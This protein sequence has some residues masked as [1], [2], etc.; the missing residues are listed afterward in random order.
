MLANTYK[1][2]RGMS[3]GPELSPA[4]SK[5][6]ESAKEDERILRNIFFCHSQAFS[7][8][9]SAFMLYFETVLKSPDTQRLLLTFS[10][11]Y[12]IFRFCHFTEVKN[13]SAK[14]V[15]CFKF[16]LYA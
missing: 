5:L 7:E 12:E 2:Q 9:I 6:L 15:W 16:Q 4:I 11:V 8:L 1:Q 14:A 10:I 3:V 13:T